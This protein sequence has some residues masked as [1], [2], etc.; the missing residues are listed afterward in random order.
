M[1]FRVIPNMNIRMWAL[2]RHMDSRAVAGAFQENPEIT[3]LTSVAPTKLRP[4]GYGR[5]RLA[6]R[7]DLKSRKVFMNGRRALD[8][9]SYMEVNYAENSHRN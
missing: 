4:A 2:S 1:A 8:R 3:V 9:L 7:V 6:L 5:G